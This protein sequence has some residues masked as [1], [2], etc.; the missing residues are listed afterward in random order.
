MRKLAIALGAGVLLSAC[1]WFG[2]GSAPPPP[3]AV[4]C[5]PMKANVAVRYRGEPP[6]TTTADIDNNLT[7]ITWTAAPEK[8]GRTIDGMTASGAST[9]SGTP[10][11]AAGQG[12][13]AGASFTLKVTGTINGPP[14]R[15]CTG[16]GTFTI[17][18]VKG[19]PLAGGTWSLQ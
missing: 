7:N 19:A 1:G 12:T 9:P 15:P 3:V 13:K 10:F 2:G 5:G 18:D 16:T 6:Q 8:T 11:T 4:G 17:V 14:P